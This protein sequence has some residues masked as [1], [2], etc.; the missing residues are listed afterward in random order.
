MPFIGGIK[1][2]SIITHYLRYKLTYKFMH[3]IYENIVYNIDHIFAAVLFCYK[4]DI[5][6]TDYLFHLLTN[7]II[8][9]RKETHYHLHSTI[10]L[11][12]F[13]LLIDENFQPI[14]NI[15]K[16]ALEKEIL[17][18]NGNNIDQNNQTVGNYKNNVE[19]TANH[20]Y[21]N[22]SND[23]YPN[24][25]EDKNQNNQ[26]EP[27]SF[28]SYNNAD[29]EEKLEDNITI[30]IEKI[31]EDYK[32]NKDDYLSSYYLDQSQEFRINHQKL[33]S[34]YRFHE[35]RLDNL[36][37]VFK[38]ELCL[39]K[40]LKKIIKSSLNLKINQL[41]E[42]NFNFIYE[43]D[44]KNFKHDYKKYFSRDSKEHHI[45]C[46]RFRIAKNSDIGVILV[47]GYSAAPKEL[48]DLAEYLNQ[49]NM[50]VYQ[51]RLKGHGTTPNNMEDVSF[52]D[53]YDSFNRGYAALKSRYSKIFFVGFSTGGLLSLLAAS[54]KLQPPTGIV[55]I[56]AA[57]S[58]KDIRINF[59]K[60]V[61][62]WNE[63]VGKITDE[64]SLTKRYVKNYAENPN[65]NYNKNYLKAVIE[66]QKLMESCY[67]SLDKIVSPTLIMQ[68]SNDPIVKPKS[69]NMI[70]DRLKTIKKELY[71]PEL[72]FH[73]ILTKK[74]KLRAIIFRKLRRFILHYDKN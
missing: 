28:K 35:I 21:S 73:T 6:K 13:K 10:R 42:Q 70:Y 69:A 18:L 58:L 7:I 39:H 51:V 11:N 49:H 19:Q 71:M 44:I 61:H 20:P 22:D 48:E 64:K 12:Y 53:W 55:T 1:R 37:A 41:K 47:H 17:F 66:L 36:F 9:I 14:D 52:N 3:T 65:I 57:L 60:T 74:S 15:I 23:R 30:D 72:D 24:K 54:R 46:P 68:A 40:P 67:Q 45:G 59:V 27:R 4:S 31:A 63:L 8:R 38:N 32:N 29:L 16:F 26:D 50:N 2:N 62:F 43:E 33:Q 5:I 56:N 34:R 25:N